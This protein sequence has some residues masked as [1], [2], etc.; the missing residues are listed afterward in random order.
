MI[1]QKFTASLALAMAVT[2]GPIS[3]ET[4]LIGQVYPSGSVYLL[5]PDEAVAWPDQATLLGATSPVPVVSHLTQILR[6]V[7]P[8]TQENAPSSFGPCRPDAGPEIE[9]ESKDV[10][11]RGMS[12]NCELDARVGLYAPAA[13]LGGSGL[14]FGWD[15]DLTGPADHT[16]AGQPRPVDAAEVAAYRAGFLSDYLAAYGTSFDPETS[17]IGEIPTKADATI[18]AEF[19]AA[20]AQ[21]RLSQWERIS[22]AQHIYHHY[23]V[24]VIRK[25]QVMQ[26]FEFT[27]FQGVLG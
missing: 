20:D 21:L 24:D 1:R 27:R 13:A 5:I 12:D 17:T 16:M 7:H 9:A 10:F 25:G 3:A 19:P 22:P 6:D 2:I 26:S 23:I 15:G 14:V 18:I 11:A 8:P 4:P